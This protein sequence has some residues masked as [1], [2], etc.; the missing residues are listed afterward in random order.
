MA[1]GKLTTAASLVSLITAGAGTVAGAVIWVMQEGYVKPANEKLEAYN[2][3][4]GSAFDCEKKINELAREKSNTELAKSATELQDATRKLNDANTRLD[5]FVKECG[6]PAECV[7]TLKKFKQADSDLKQ[8]Q[9]K[10][11][12]VSSELTTAK[13]DLQRTSKELADVRT[14]FSEFKQ[15]AD[16]QVRSLDQQGS[17]ANSP[18]VDVTKPGSVPS[19]ATGSELG[20]KKT[21]SHKPVPPVT[22]TTTPGPSETAK[23]GTPAPN[24]KWM[25]PESHTEGSLAQLRGLVVVL[26]WCNA[27]CPV[28]VRHAKAGTATKVLANF[29]GRPV[30][31]IF[32]DST[33][34]AT[35]ASTSR[36]Q[37]DNP[38]PGQYL[39]D[40]TGATGKAYGAKTTPHVFVID[41][42][43]NLA[44][45]GAI[46]DDNNGNKGDTTKSY[47]KD[48]VDA[49]LQGSPV[50]TSTTD[51]YGCAVKYKR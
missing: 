41:Q 50:A 47:V 17:D 25:N 30:D 13:S 19:K 43:G 32:V 33:F 1:D 36:F 15:K 49:L 23:L 46:D 27:S 42:N 34:D 7:E 40:P 28:S 37:I 18:R 9:T 21:P 6:A 24:F 44:Y 39:L 45:A 10:A 11:A 20:G 38:Q 14:E 35:I 51:P 4:C 3:I 2:K 16:K 29:E 12:R 5:A 22:L 8:F 48:A 26:Q 31:W